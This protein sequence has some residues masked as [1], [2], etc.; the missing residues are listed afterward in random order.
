MAAL[1]PF[2][3]RPALAVAVSGGADSMALCLLADGWARARGGRV[4]ALIIDHGLR[5]SSAGEAERTA[6]WL[7]ARGIDSS[8]LP[9]LGD[10][11]RSAI[12]ARAR[13]ERYRLLLEGCRQRGILHLL[14][15]HHR[16]DQAETLLLRQARGSGVAGLTGMSGLVE[17]GALRV[18]RPLLEVPKGRLRAYLESLGQ[19]W[20]ED[21]SN[22]DPAYA[23]AR[24]RAAPAVGTGA[25]GG[26]LDAAEACR[27]ARQA[28]DEA[29]AELLAR[30]CRVHPCGFVRLDPEM[31]GVAEEATVAA[32][33]G[34][35]A[36]TVGGTVYPPPAEK[37][38]RLRRCLTGEAPAASLG[39][40]VWRGRGGGG[41][42]GRLILVLREARGLP[43]PVRIVPER[44]VEW[45]GRF[46]LRFPA[47]GAWT[48]RQLI[49]AALGGAGWGEAVRLWPGL[50]D[51]LPREAAVSLPA[52]YD[53]FGL[54][55]APNLGLCRDPVAEGLAGVGFRPRR[56]L[57]GPGYCL[58]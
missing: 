25:A 51:E 4:L 36:A 3:K 13:A 10:K 24:L 21:P 54:V 41:G 45:D 33:L 2:E 27:H 11:P 20:I 22:A 19:A 32:A 58:A 17:T 40:C 16:Q 46:V 44:E 31:L 52:I 38:A 5:P 48:D 50:A 30:F 6:R 1:A 7:A 49:L 55:A 29:V 34:R 39:R 35:I 42:T 15:G 26:L 12:Q 23:R 43:Q 57:S 9:W 53:Q 47:K 28:R 18:L 37:I 8:I 14:V 56:S